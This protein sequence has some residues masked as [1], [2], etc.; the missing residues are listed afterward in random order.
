[1][2]NYLVKFHEEF[3]NSNKI[4]PHFSGF[5]FHGPEFIK[6][7]AFPHFAG[8]Q[9]FIYSAKVDRRKIGAC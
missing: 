1:M 4:V 5:S 8:K 2:N 3:R 6:K 7:I 9:R